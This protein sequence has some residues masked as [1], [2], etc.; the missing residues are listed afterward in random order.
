MTGVNLDFLGKNA[1]QG[2][3]ASYIAGKGL[4]VNAMRPFIGND[5]RP[6]ISVFK[7]G[8]PKKVENYV[9]VQVNSATLR[10]D[11][12]KQL[13]EAIIPIAQQRLTGIQDL[14][15]RDLV[16]NLGN[17]FGT[18]VLE[19]H[20]ISDAMDAIVTMDGVTRGK[21]DRGTYEH[22]YLPIPIIHSDY[23][24]NMR[25]LEAS[26][27]LG[28]P[29]DTDN[30]ERAVRKVTEKLEGLLF[31]DVDYSFGGGT[32]Y[33]YL[34]FPTRNLAVIRN[35]A[36]ATGAQIVEDVLAMKQESIDNLHYG[37]WVVYIPTG[38]ETVLDADYD[39]TTPGTTIRERILKIAGIEAVKVVDMLPAQNVLLVQM[40]SSV[41]RLVRGMGIQNVQWQTEGGMVNMYK[42]MTIQVPQI[43]ADYNGKTGIVHA[44]V[45]DE[46]SSS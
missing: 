43:R 39:A 17:A 9:N 36:T 13:D 20:A 32:I 25:V 37:P 24:I 45:A 3:V 10:R 18:T 11:E 8:D 30:A 41:I 28:N 38:Y 7:G 4:N 1:S 5:G 12:W 6:Y 46:S 34:N 33:S 14:I 44:S 21:G 35:W 27:K 23:E 31:T 22:K 29:L 26:R 42:V 40:T 16:Y 2:D 19:T 15:S